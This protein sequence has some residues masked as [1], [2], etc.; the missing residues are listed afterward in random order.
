MRVQGRGEGGE[1]PPERV[2][3]G[4][5]LDF[6]GEKKHMFCVD[7]SVCSTSSTDINYLEAVSGERIESGGLLRNPEGREVRLLFQSC[8]RE[9]KKGK[10]VTPRDL[11][12]RHWSEG[13]A[14]ITPEMF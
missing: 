10:W 7:H 1:E 14:V 9:Y 8:D 11:V 4:L 3:L 12:T 5:K 13:C 6:L 2:E